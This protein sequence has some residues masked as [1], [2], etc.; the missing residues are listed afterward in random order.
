MKYLFVIF[1]GAL[2]SLLRF[3]SSSWVASLQ[4]GSYFPWGTFY[5]NLVG[6][7]VIGSLAGLQQ[8]TPFSMNS[9]LFLFTGLLGGFTTYSAY[10]LE[11][12]T[13]FKEDQGLLAIVYVL[14]T[15]ILGLAFAA[16]GYWLI[17]FLKS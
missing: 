5:V 7:F 8:I 9:R 16:F 6:S 2:G 14:S 15:T 1:G 12:F 13:L 4:V 10:A 3:I 11:T 17:Q